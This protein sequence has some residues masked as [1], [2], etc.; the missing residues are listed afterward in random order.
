VGTI[1]EARQVL[2]LATGQ[3]KAA[4]VA[5]AVEGPVTAMVTASALQM[6][7]STQVLLDEEAASELKMRDYYDWVQEKKPGAPKV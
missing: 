6:H 3:K 5:A 4:A 2:L 1:L 7:P